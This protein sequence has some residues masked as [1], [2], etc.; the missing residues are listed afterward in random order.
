MGEMVPEQGI[1]PLT[2]GFKV[3]RPRLQT[4][5]YSG[6]KMAARLGFEPSSAVSETA[7]LT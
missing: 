3:P 2:K 5:G 1:E 7:I 4:L 6:S